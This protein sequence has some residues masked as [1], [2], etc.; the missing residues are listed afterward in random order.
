MTDAE[1]KAL[2]L[3]SLQAG[4]QRAQEAVQRV[5]SY[6]LDRLVKY[7]PRSSTDQIAC[8]VTDALLHPGHEARFFPKINRMF[9]RPVN[10]EF[11]QKCLDAGRIRVRM[12]TRR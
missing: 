2:A 11:I 3:R 5:V 6:V 4:R 12:A 9:E 8:F 1:A 7:P 10:T